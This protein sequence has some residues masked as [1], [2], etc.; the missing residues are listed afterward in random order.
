MLWA[1]LTASTARAQTGVTLRVAR[2]EGVSAD[3]G[4]VMTTAFT[5]RNSGND[6]AHVVVS[7]AVPAGWLALTGRVNVHVAPHDRDVVLLSVATP[8][9]APAGRY[10]LRASVDDQTTADSLVVT[11]REHRA[12]EVLP[13]DAPGWVATGMSFAARFLVRNH[14]N[15]PATY[16]LDGTSVQR[17]R[18]RTEPSV[19]Q[20]PPGGTAVVEVRGMS[21]PGLLNAVDD[22]VE[23]RVSDRDDNSVS[24]SASQHTTFVPRGTVGGKIGRAHV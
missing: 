19:A 14:G 5:L 22:L 24:A 8:S 17:V 12:V 4:D 15:L 18:M 6:S 9:G 23:L 7:L 3:A 21:H 13:L 1:A 2:R 10:V 20:L 16:E 11:V